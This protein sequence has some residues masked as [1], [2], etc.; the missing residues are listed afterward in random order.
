MNLQKQ[1]QI[2]QQTHF[3]LLKVRLFSY[4]FNTPP[5]VREIRLRILGKLSPMIEKTLI[6]DF[7]GGAEQVFRQC[8]VWKNGARDATFF[9][10]ESSTKSAFFKLFLVF[11]SVNQGDLKDQA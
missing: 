4:A 9:L 10:A 6:S 1:I 7:C 11:L 5:T 2:W 3:H 8:I